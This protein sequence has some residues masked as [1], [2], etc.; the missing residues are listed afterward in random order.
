[1]TISSIKTEIRCIGSANLF[2]GGLT[3]LLIALLV[4][5]ACPTPYALYKILNMSA[6]MPPIWLTVLAMSAFFFFAGAAFFGALSYRCE[7]IHK[8]KGGMFFVIMMSLCL[9]WY[10]IFFSLK[11]FIL[12]LAV[13][14]FSCICAF[15]CASSYLRISR[16]LGSLMTLCAL[17][18]VY[19]TLVNA[20][21]LFQNI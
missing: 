21:C 2:I 11:L 10:P 13:S 7:D 14:A 17:W 9:A 15:A 12:S 4:R 8:Y 16:F 20:F 1:M 5:L 6:F 18:L 19:L 3:F